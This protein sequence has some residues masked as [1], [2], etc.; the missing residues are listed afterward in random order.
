MYVMLC[1]DLCITYIMFTLYKIQLFLTAKSDIRICIGLAPWI[2]IRIE[3]K[4]RI[5]IS[6]ETNAGP[7]RHKNN[8][9][10]LE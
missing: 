8:S 9:K 4:S 7:H 3:V 6:I 10:L 2:W 5:R 1:I